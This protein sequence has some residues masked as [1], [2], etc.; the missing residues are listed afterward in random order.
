M[1]SS[2]VE[3]YSSLLFR[4]EWE[5][6]SHGDNEVVEEVCRLNSTIVHSMIS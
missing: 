1:E 4:G 2:E 3:S 5:K 6:D